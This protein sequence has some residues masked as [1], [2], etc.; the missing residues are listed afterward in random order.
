MMLEII[1]ANNICKIA[2]PKDLRD[3][4]PCSPGSVLFDSLCSR[5]LYGEICQMLALAPEQQTAALLEL[6]SYP[7]GAEAGCVVRWLHREAP[8]IDALHALAAELIAAGSRVRL[9]VTR[10]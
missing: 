6:E 5:P 1:T 3:A 7:P 2:T 9:V 4:L 10:E 8:A